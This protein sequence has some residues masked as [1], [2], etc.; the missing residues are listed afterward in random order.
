MENIDYLS[1]RTTNLN[2][3][4]SPLLKSSLIEKA[5]GMG[6]NL[7]DFIMHVLTKS[8]SG[9]DKEKEENKTGLKLLEKENSTLQKEL[10]QYKALAKPFEK[11]L[12]QAIELNGQAVQIETAF[13]VLK[14]MSQTFKLK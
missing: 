6:L 13:D 7:S 5:A 4:I 14:L 10:N 3:R 11:L 12:G 9:Q 8:M 2:I 1:M